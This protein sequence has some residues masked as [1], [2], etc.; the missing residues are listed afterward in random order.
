MARENKFQADLI[1]RIKEE[2]PG[3]MVLK[4]DSGY[5]QGVPD[6]LILYGTRWA[7]LEVK[8]SLDAPSQPNQEYYRHK[9]DAMSFADVVAPENEEEIIHD[10][11]LA[12][13][14]TRRTRVSGR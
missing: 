13:A 9:F 1:K 8:R 5:L 10:L 14:L 2:L 7:M 12:L 4:N 3:C 11:Q 6:L